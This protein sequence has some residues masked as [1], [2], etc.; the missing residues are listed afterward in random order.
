MRPRTG[1][2]QSQQVEPVFAPK[3]VL[4]LVLD[5]DPGNRNKRKLPLSGS[6]ARECSFSSSQSTVQAGGKVMLG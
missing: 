4:P 3:C 6:S 1:L 2:A 5:Y